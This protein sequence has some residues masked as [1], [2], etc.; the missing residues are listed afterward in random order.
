LPDK[1]S[2]GRAVYEEKVKHSGVART[3]SNTALNKRAGSWALYL[4]C[5]YSKGSMALH[6]NGRLIDRS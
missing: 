5:N 1:P 2:K 3:R 6:S 4:A